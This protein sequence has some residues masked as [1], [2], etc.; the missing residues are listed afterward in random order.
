MHL[1][2]S[3]HVYP[4]DASD[5]AKAGDYDGPAISDRD[6]P[7]DRVILLIRKDAPDVLLRGRDVVSAAGEGTVDV[8]VVFVPTVA[9]WNIPGAAMRVFR[10]RFRFKSS[11]SYHVGVRELRGMGLERALRTLEHPQARVGKNRA[12]KMARLEGSLRTR[13]YDDSRPLTVM[14]CRTRGIADSIRQ[15]HHRISACMECGIP[16]VTV[17][18][19][20][21]GA[22]PRFLARLVGRPARRLDV[23]KQAI[24]SSCGRTVKR[25]VPIGDGPMPSSFIVV[26]E[27]GGRFVLDLRDG[28]FRVS[29]EFGGLGG[30]AR[31]VLIPFVVASAV[32]LDIAVMKTA[33]GDHSLVAWSQFVLSAASSVLVSIAAVVERNA[34]AGYGAMAFTLASMAVYE[35]L[36]DVMDVDSDAVGPTAAIAAVA[37]TVGAA[38]CRSFATGARRMFASR[39]FSAVPFGFTFIWGASK[40]LGSRRIWGAMGLEESELRAVKHVVEEGTELL[41]YATIA[42]WAILFF[43]DRLSNWR[44]MR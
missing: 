44:K 41:G 6:L 17:R 33:C 11:L 16:R 13:G 4:L 9:K 34:R 36:R 12:E 30:L 20:A 10:N 26:P 18:F 22:L 24:E 25:L 40:L 35:L 2:W 37:W 21:A 23:A 29:D 7:D 15:G 31:G 8:R 38:F 5:V 3:S 43:S 19:A 42:C 39:A 1:G 28:G 27:A 14:L 32:G